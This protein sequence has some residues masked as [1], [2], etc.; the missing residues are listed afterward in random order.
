[1]ALAL[2]PL[3]AGCA[4]L[5]APDCTRFESE[6]KQTQYTPDYELL[7]SQTRQFAPGFR[8]LTGQS[9]VAVP[10]FKTVT[11]D[12][13]AHHC[14]HLVMT[15]DLFLQRAD[16][17]RKL[18]IEETRE[19]YTTAGKQVATRTVDLSPQFPATGYYSAKE[20][21]PIPEA[22]PAGKYR[23]VTRLTY[24]TAPKAKPVL[25]ARSTMDFAV[26]AK[27]TR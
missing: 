14:T 18:I 4:T 8:P 13:A 25:L 22:T 9:P 27:K 17:T 16:K 15:K 24:R 7:A 1:V 2:S 5:L 23:I 3:A 12:D 21:L 10:F 6:R 19:I 11:T 20:R 26:L